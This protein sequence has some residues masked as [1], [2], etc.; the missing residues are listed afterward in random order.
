VNGE[1][2]ADIATVAI[3]IA[4]AANTIVKTGLAIGIGGWALG[5]RVTIIG[6]LILVAGGAGLVPVLA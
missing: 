6:A 4:I 5:K 3:T 2:A 1:L